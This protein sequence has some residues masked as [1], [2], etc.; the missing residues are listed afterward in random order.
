M[1]LSVIVPV[2]NEVDTIQ[3]VLE[4]VQNVRLDKEIIIVD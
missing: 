1:K 3:T 4:K 2:Y